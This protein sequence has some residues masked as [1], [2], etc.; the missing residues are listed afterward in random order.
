[1]PYNLYENVWRFGMDAGEVLR[2]LEKELK[3]FEDLIWIA[4]E[5][6]ISVKQKNITE[7]GQWIEQRERLLFEIEVIEVRVSSRL[8]NLYKDPSVPPWIKHRLRKINAEIIL[9]IDHILKIERGG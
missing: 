7:V 6:L 2:N 1:M 8:E 4:E 5:K 3:L 9:M